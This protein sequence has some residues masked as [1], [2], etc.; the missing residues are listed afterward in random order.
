MLAP[1]FQGVQRC[2]SR[3]VPLGLRTP[4]DYV[5]PYP[6]ITLDPGRENLLRVR[7]DLLDK[8]LKPLMRPSPHARRLAGL[9]RGA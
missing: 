8:T 1:Y 3:V 2:N 6:V 9:L 4:G 5:G 7:Y